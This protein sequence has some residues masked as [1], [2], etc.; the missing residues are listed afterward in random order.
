MKLN[1]EMRAA[2]DDARA[3][4][5]RADLPFEV[6]A[7]SLDAYSPEGLE[8]LAT[9]GVTDVIVGFRD[10]YRPGPDTQSLDE[11]VSMMQWYADEIISKFR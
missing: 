1:D 6:H 10:A 11:K 8:R 5:G 9:A 4:H 3:R 7:I 2:I